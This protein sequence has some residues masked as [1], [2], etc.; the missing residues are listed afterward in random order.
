[1][2]ALQQLISKLSRGSS[3]SGD[4]LFALLLVVTMVASLS[5]LL[6]MLA[7]RWGDRNIAFKSLLASILIHS[8]CFLG[9]EVFE[10][11]SSR[12][13]KAD[14][15]RPPL[16]VAVTDVLVEGQD[17][18]PLAT[19]SWLQDSDSIII[20]QFQKIVILLNN[21]INFESTYKIILHE[22]DVEIKQ[23]FKT[24]NIYRV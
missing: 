24:D 19:Y 1:M 11:T 17:N 10:P 9:L 20:I 7:T 22:T 2:N 18:V 3:L 4:D 14:V 16:P 12:R 6:T 23:S 21:S 5:H 8:V 15:P 13:A